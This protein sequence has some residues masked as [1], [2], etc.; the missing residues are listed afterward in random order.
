MSRIVLG[1]SP[2]IKIIEGPSR[3]KT[4]DGKPSRSPYFRDLEENL[5]ELMAAD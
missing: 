3:R 1:F 5:M 2:A 4:A